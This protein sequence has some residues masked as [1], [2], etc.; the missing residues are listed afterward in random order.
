[1]SPPP[2]RRI[3]RLAV[4]FYL[5]MMASAFFARPPGTLVVQE[6]QRLALGLAMALAAGLVVVAA[7]RFFA[8]RTG[9]GR[10]LRAELRSV[11]GTLGSREILLL[12]LLSA[13][14]EE[15]LFR[16]AIHPRLGLW[17]TALLFGAFH[18]PYRRQLLPWSLFALVLGVGLGAMTDLFGSLW[19]AILLHFVVNYRNLH[20]L[21]AG[22]ALPRPEG[23]PR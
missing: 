5:P 15:F 13:F 21:A 14:G 9:W 12:A 4:F 10:A 11:L 8:S 3:V 19:P 20:D 18:F 22:P 6:P 16:G 2:P 17:G 23:E 7:S 1:M